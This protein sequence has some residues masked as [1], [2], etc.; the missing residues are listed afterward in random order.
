VVG[1]LGSQFP[2]DRPRLVEEVEEP[3]EEIVG[4]QT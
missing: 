3:R 4:H 1:N 2:V